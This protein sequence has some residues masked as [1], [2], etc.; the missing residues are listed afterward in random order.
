MYSYKLY[1]LVQQCWN[2][3]HVWDM[4]ARIANISLYM[5]QLA[6]N[7]SYALSIECVYHYIHTTLQTNIC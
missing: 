7:M 4:F 3:N 2:V 1:V 5:Y 6:D